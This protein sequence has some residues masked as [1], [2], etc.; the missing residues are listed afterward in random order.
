MSAFRHVSGL[1]SCVTHA[2]RN[3]FSKRARY[4]TVRDVIHCPGIGDKEFHT[5]GTRIITLFRQLI[6]TGKPPIP[7]GH[8]LD[9]I[10]IIEAAGIAQKEGRR[11]ALREVLDRA[12][13]GDQ[14]DESW[15][16]GR[17]Q[18]GRACHQTH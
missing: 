1:P 12:S 4:R 2:T 18:Y 10:A 8:I 11:V 7:Y 5:G 16:L 6:D 15:N 17:W 13:K 14:R 3:A 9:P